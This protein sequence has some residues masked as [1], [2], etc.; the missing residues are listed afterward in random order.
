MNCPR[1]KLE[2]PEIGFSVGDE[3]NY[4][5]GLIFKIVKID[6]KSQVCYDTKG[7]WYALTNCVNISKSPNNP[8]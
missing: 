4:C 2:K 6:E 8:Q 1:K 5:N 7:M 3:V